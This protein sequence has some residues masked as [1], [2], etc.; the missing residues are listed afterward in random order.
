M[1]IVALDEQRL[2]TAP[3]IHQCLGLGRDTK[4]KTYESLSSSCAVRNLFHVGNKQ[5]KVWSY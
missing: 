3:S 4:T 5:C 1:V 2:M